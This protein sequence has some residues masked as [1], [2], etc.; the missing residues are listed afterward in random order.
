MPVDHSDDGVSVYDPTLGRHIATTNSRPTDLISQADVV[1]VVVVVVVY[2][3]FWVVVCVVIAE[4]AGTTAKEP[5]I[6]I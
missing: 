6:Y 3:G 1:V 2:S 5:D 4:A